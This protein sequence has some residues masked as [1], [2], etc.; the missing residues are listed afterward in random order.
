MQRTKEVPA[1]SRETQFRALLFCKILACF[2][3]HKCA[4]THE[5]I[6]DCEI[7]LVSCTNGFYFSNT[8]TFPIRSDIPSGARETLWRFSTYNSIISVFVPD[9]PQ[10]VSV[11]RHFNTL[12][13][14]RSVLIRR[15]HSECLLQFGLVYVML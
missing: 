12:R 13:V 8:S 1:T 9:V 2:I 10:H 5:A 11:G 3:F 7:D 6:V 14:S 4:R 15:L